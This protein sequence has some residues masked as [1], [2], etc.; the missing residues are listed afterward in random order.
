[1]RH[2]KLGCT[3]CRRHTFPSADIPFTTWISQ[4]QAESLAADRDS[5]GRAGA[6]QP[7]WFPPATPLTLSHCV[8]KQ[9][10]LTPEQTLLLRSIPRFQNLVLLGVNS[11]LSSSRGGY[12]KKADLFT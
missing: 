6:A 10:R 7:R 12:R 11:L 8:S 9:T 1:M 5:A 4:A 3:T 2:L